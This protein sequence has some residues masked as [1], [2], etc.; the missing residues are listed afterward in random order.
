MPCRQGDVIARGICLSRPGRSRLNP[1]AEDSDGEL[2]TPASVTFALP[3]VFTGAEFPRLMEASAAEPSGHFLSGPPDSTHERWMREFFVEQGAAGACAQ[4]IDAVA[5]LVCRRFSRHIN[6]PS[7]PRG[8]GT[9]A[10]RRRPAL[11]RSR[12]LRSIGEG[13]LGKLLHTARTAAE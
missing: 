8:N 1:L 6:E 9:V 11:C 10:V 3:S 7:E 5:H 2:K 13:T 4:P 12:R